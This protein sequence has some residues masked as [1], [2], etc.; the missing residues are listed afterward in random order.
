MT[1]PP[2]AAATPFSVAT[3]NVVSLTTSKPAAQ[4]SDGLTA[5]TPCSRSLYPASGTATGAQ[6]RPL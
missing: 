6:A 5:L 1:E 2:L 3:W 4:T